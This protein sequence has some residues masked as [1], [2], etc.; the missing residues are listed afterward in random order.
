VATHDVLTE[1][2]FIRPVAKRRPVEEDFLERTRPPKARGRF[3]WALGF[4]AIGGVVGGPFMLLAA[5]AIARRVGIDLDA[6]QVVGEIVRAWTSDAFTAGLALAAIIGAAF[7]ALFGLLT[8][9]SLR[10]PSRALTGVLLAPTVWTLFQAFVFKTYAS[11][12]LGALPFG[13]MVIGAAAFGLCT[14]ILPPPRTR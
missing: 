6:A 12:T 1:S 14:T 13:P 11:A 5:S 10:L 4:G 9:Y 7:G 2:W 3:A 8:R